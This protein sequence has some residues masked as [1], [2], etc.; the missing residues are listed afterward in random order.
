MVV[1]PTATLRLAFGASHAAPHALARDTAY[2]KRKQDLTQ[3]NLHVVVDHAHRVAADLDARVVGPGAVGQA[4]TPGVPRTRDNMV[5]HVTVAERRP[6]V[7][8]HVV[9]GEELAVD[10]EHGNQL[11]LERDGLALAF[12]D[13]R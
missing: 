11:A 1:H 5:L 10:A 8:A 12:D 2:A 4:K 6:H 3:L 7:R 9:D 13:C